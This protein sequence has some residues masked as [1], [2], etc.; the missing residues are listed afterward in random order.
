ML[1]RGATAAFIRQSLLNYLANTDYVELVVA[2]HPAFSFTIESV[3]SIEL[4]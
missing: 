2:R 3:T 4:N 1:I